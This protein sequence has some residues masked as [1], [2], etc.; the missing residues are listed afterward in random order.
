MLQVGVAVA[1]L[2]VYR[3]A[4]DA[5]RR[6]MPSHFAT[7]MFAVYLCSVCSVQSCLQQPG[8]VVAVIDA[9]QGVSSCGQPWL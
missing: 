4:L 5:Q 2:H 9:H 8:L 7:V 3:R 6:L 1:Q